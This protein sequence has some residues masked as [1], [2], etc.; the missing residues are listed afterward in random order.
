MRYSWQI[1]D[2]GTIALDGGGM[3]GVVPKV[4][5]ERSF[6]A[7]EKNRITL[8]HNCLLLKSEDGKRTVLIETGSGDKFGEK[9]KRIFGL[10]ERSI[11]NALAE[12]NADPGDLTNVVVSHLHFDHAGGLTKLD[13][14][15]PVLS[16]PNAVVHVQEREYRDAIDN[17]TVM[18]KTYLPENLAPL[19]KNLRLAKGDGEIMPGVYAFAV[20]GHTWGQQAISFTDTSDR[21]IVFVPDVMPTAS[22]VGRAYSMAFDVEPY[23]TSVTKKA[24][25]R[26][27]AKMN[28]HLV[29]A[30]EP[31]TPF[32]TVKEDGKGWY[33]LE[34]QTP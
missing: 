18:S 30:H 17:R 15:D 7:D 20:P 29:L 3:F 11:H 27:A 13:D 14:D 8:A 33:E 16:F 2:A 24:M 12:A 9:D 23:T 6:P 19:E 25:L 22:H 26:D 21:S 1:L 31:K 32:V 28:L 5:W 34:P 4:L 10:G